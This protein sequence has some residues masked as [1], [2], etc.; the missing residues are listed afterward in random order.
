MS[1]MP[2]GGWLDPPQQDAEQETD[3]IQRVQVLAPERPRYQSRNPT[4][5]I[6]D[7]GTLISKRLRRLSG[8]AVAIGFILLIPSVIGMISCAVMFLAFNSTVGAALGINAKGSGHL[9]Q[10]AEEAKFR[11]GCK[12]GFLEATPPLQGV[13][14][15]QFCECVLSVYKETGS[16]EGASQTCTDRGFAGT[17]EQPNQDVEALYSSDISNATK[18]GLT[19]AVGFVGNAFLLGLGIA[20][21]VSGLL[22][23]LLTMKKRVLQ[24]D[25]CGAVVNAS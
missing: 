22:G 7:R 21:F 8:P 2:E 25:V 10:S 23:W 14:V 9:Y 13:S 19:T 16:V 24:C 5:K 6:C 18:A 12:E 17:L 15:P 4:C 20:L 1:I 11:R 3:S